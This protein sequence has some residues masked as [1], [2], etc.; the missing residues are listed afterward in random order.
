M[1][2]TPSAQI[3]RAASLLCDSRLK[4]HRFA[5]FPSDCRPVDEFEAYATQESLHRKLT[6]QGWGHVVGHKI[7]CTTQ[8]MQAYLGIENPC[9]GGVFDLTVQHEVGHFPIPHGLR[10]GVECEIA[11][12]I[13]TDL[14]AHEAPFGRDELSAAVQGCL[15]AIEI[16]ED[17]YTNYQQL[18][19]PTLIADDFFGAGCVLGGVDRGFSVLDLS[20]V[21]A[22][23]SINGVEVGAGKG[24]D[25]LGDPLNA[26]AWL[27]QN[28]AERGQGLRRGEFVLLG[29]LVQTHWVQPGDQVFIRNDPLG[30]AQASFE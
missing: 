7:G 12:L 10:V 21:T 6:D 1:T 19:T 26:L 8:V 9:G 4:R 3:D 20:A 27:A 25:V 2:L 15:A 17:R 22:Q 14:H 16:V 11:V 28:L 29:S 23:M 5:T 30:A 24:T 13:G 18:D